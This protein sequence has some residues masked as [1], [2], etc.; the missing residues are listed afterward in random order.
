[1]SIFLDAV[2]AAREYA[3]LPTCLLAVC[4]C[5]LAYLYL[6][7]RRNLPPGPRGWPIVGNMPMFNKSAFL[8]VTLTELAKQYGDVMTIWTGR[9]PTVVLTGHKTIRTALVKRAEDFSSRKSNKIAAKFRGDGRT[10]FGVI[11]ASYGPNW[12]HQ[13]KFALVTLRDFG[14]GKRSLEGKIKEEV[15]MLV[16]EVLLQNGQPFDSKIMI[17]YCV[18]DIIISITFG[19]RLEYDNPE[20]LRL[21]RLLNAAVGVKPSVPDLLTTMIHPVFQHLCRSETS[22]IVTSEKMYQA[23]R[24]FCAE[25]IEKHRSTFDPNDIRDLSTL[26]S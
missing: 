10:A 8:P 4:L 15:D 16:Q 11:M 20:F 6:Q 9:F 7:R 24:E 2:T 13:R 19:D 25:Q 1:M 5:L 22:M 12:K 14:V 18:S 21:I 17:Q 26:F 23:L 3:D